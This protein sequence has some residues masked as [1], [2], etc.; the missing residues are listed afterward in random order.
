MA[1]KYE[2]YERTTI[3]P[4]AFAILSFLAATPGDALS[5][6]G[7]GCGKL[8]GGVQLPCSGPNFEAFA[9]TAC[10]LGRTYLHPLV[11]QVVLEAFEELAK[12]LPNRVWQYGE[13]GN[14]KGGRL[15][16]HKT[17]QNGLAADFFVPVLNQQGKPDKVSVSVFNKFGYGLEFDNNGQHDRLTIDWKAI[18]A[19]LLALEAAGQKH[20]VRIERVIITP[21][22]RKILLR[23]APELER[24]E[25][26]FMKKE[27]WVRH[28]E[29]YH[30]D[31]DIPPS[32]RRPLNCQK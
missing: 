3:N 10:H 9:D 15:W 19:H 31:F 25:S 14:A 32:L 18:A 7:G 13:M 29:H 11:Q 27:A 17:H 12:K 21:A 23:Q 20:S 24:M 16:P 2:C 6:G 1:V 8:E 30:I 26:L 28:D 5:F 22:F 4:S